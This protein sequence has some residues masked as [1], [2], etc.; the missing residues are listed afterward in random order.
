MNLVHRYYL[1]PNQ[2]TNM[3]RN[4]SPQ[5]SAVLFSDTTVKLKKSW[6]GMVQVGKGFTES[7]ILLSVFRVRTSKYLIFKKLCLPLRP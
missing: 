6:K 1:D 3:S 5:M 4:L 2:T 7:D